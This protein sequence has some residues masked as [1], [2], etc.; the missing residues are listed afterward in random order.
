MKG[1]TSI[2]KLKE[3]FISQ[4]L[5]VPDVAYLRARIKSIKT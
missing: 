3:D 5:V 4:G 1:E 2:L